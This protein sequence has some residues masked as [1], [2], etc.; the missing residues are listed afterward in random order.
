MP[1]HLKAQKVAH[2]FFDLVAEIPGVQL[3]DLSAGCCGMA[4][5]FGT[6]AGSFEFSM[7]TGRPVFERV[8]E[9]KPNLVLSDCSSCRMQIEQGTGVATMHPAELLAHLYGVAPARHT[10]SWTG[11]A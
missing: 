5:T 3:T 11:N 6:K 8:Q 10:L 4:G 7:L 1:C 9:V 2:T